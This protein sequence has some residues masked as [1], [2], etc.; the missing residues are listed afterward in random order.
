[1]NRRSAT[2]SL[3]ALGHAGVRLASVAQPTGRA[4]RI[5]IVH[6]VTPNLM[7]PYMAAFLASLAERGNVVGRNLIVDSR[8]A[9]GDPKRYPAL[10]DEVMR[11]KPDILIGAN[12]EVAL[13]MKARTRTIPIVL[14]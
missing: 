7:K 11:L 3:I 13:L 4:W 10:L 8:S 14:A 12:T 9:E 5:G 6:G 2:R 1:M